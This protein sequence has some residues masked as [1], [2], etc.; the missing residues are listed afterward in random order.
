M[1][2][3]SDFARKSHSFH[4]HFFVKKR[5][6]SKKSCN[7]LSFFLK[8]FIKNPRTSQYLVKKRPFSKKH[9]VLVIIFCPIKLNSLKKRCTHIILF[10][11]F[12]WKTFCCHT[13]IWTKTSILSNYTIIWGKTV[14]KMTFFFRF[15]W[16]NIAL[17]HIFCK[18][19]CV[20]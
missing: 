12:K 16:K 7:L 13:H 5:P 11:N 10:S 2:F 9:T 19:T 8:I 20:L 15:S 1:L 6:F 18:K 4:V 17:M 14:N 3:F